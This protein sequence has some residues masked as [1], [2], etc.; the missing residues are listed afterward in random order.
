MPPRW[1]FCSLRT[2]ADFDRVFDGGRRFFRR[3]LGFYYRL[4][5]LEVFRYGIST[6]R[7]FGIA[8]ERN[9]FRRRVREALRLS[10]ERSAGIEMVICLSRKCSEVGYAEVCS[11]IEWALRRIRRDNAAVKTAHEAVKADDNA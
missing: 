7:R 8:V 2:R 6:P 4:T 11:T 1:T 5:S 9:K 3:G 10:G